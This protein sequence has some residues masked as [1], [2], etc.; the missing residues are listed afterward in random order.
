MA[1]APS[2]C[3]L[4]DVLVHPGGR[5]RGVGRTL[6]EPVLE[7]Y[8]AVRQRV[9][10]TDDDPAQRAFYESLGFCEIREPGVGSLRG[11]VRFDGPAN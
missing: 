10:L 1:T 6:V 9:L 2:I 7:P 5:P 3:D 8:A 4:Q 11:F